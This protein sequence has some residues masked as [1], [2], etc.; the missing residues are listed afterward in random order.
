MQNLRSLKA[1]KCHFGILVSKFVIFFYS[2]FS[3]MLTGL[4]VGYTGCFRV[5]W[6]WVIAIVL[7]GLFLQILKTCQVCNFTLE[8]EPLTI[9]APLNAAFQHI[10][11]QDIDIDSIV[12]YHLTNVPKTTDQ[13]GGSYSSLNARLAGNPPLW[14]THNSGRYHNDIYVN[15]ARL[16]LGQSNLIGQKDGPKGT[17]KQILHKIDEVLIPTRSSLTA[18]NPVFNPTAWEFLENYESL[19]QGPHRLRTFRQRVQQNNK[20]NIFKDEGVQSFFIPVDEG[21]VNSRA[22][23]IDEIIIDGHVIPK[24]VLFTTPTQKDYPFPTLAN[25]DNVI[26]VVI[27]F[28]QE[29]RGN[30]IKNY[31]KSHTLIGDGKHTP[32][33]VLAEIVKA[34]IPV[35]NGVIHLIHKPLMIVDST[36]K[37]LLQEHAD[38]ICRVGKVQRMHNILKE[39]EIL[40]QAVYDKDGNILSNFLSAVNG[41][42]SAGQDFLKTIEKAQDVTLF[43][44][45]N[46]AMEGSLVN[47]MLKNA[48]KFMEILKMH[49]VVDNRLYADII[50]Q[51]V[52]N[53][54]HQAPSLAKGKN[55]YFNIAKNSKN[56]T[57]TV[58]GGGVNATVIQ[59]DL[60]A[61]NGIIH[62]IDRVLGVP[63]STILDKLRTDPMLSDSYKLGAMEGF[64]NQL[65]DLN[66]KF[67]YFVPSNRA[68]KEAQVVMP[69]AIKK[70]FMR[71]YAYH[72]TRTLQQHLIL[73]EVFTMEAI[74]LMTKTSFSNNYT[75]YGEVYPGKLR[76][77]TVSL[78]TLRGSLQLYVEEKNDNSFVIHWNDMK[79]PVFRP[80]VE[81][82]N[83]IIHVIDAPF[84]RKGDIRVSAAPAFLPSLFGLLVVSLMKYLVQ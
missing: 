75:G 57:L 51:K 30:T 6:K 62:V 37:E 70:L 18:A 60:A 4:T 79:I 78:P 34:N 21:F 31:V 40:E 3:F 82:T 13:F 58:E 32:G 43:A 35:K 73:G 22:N 8:Y 63:Y 19:I 46:E 45:C 25:Y 66:K 69:S 76:P 11:K 16:L 55:L 80:N 10:S 1:L 27:S 59:E 50:D 67:T 2:T 23:L 38:Y 33:V 48:D 9:F 7:N 61:K 53:N 81:C 49:V 12:Q 71:D 17:I 52:Q 29:Q 77:E 20:E 84:L 47:S 72:A 26:R 65:G 28:T 36:I 42:G 5:N 68:W 44:P 56:R 74:K 64:N 41:V 54:I 24:Q 83:G 15:N 39:H 14:I